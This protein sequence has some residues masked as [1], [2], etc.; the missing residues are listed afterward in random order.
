MVVN[1]DVNVAK[2][3]IAQMLAKTGPGAG[4]VHIPC[5][6][7][8]APIRGFDERVVEEFTTESCTV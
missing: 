1:V 3:Q 2:D 8:G 4:F 5:G 6:P 7:A